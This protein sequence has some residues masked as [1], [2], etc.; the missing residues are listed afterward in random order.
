LSQRALLDSADA[1]L[2]RTKAGTVTDAD[3]DHVLAQTDLLADN[4]DELLVVGLGD[5][6]GSGLIPNA[7]TY[8]ITFIDSAG[9]LI[10]PNDYTNDKR[11][12]YDFTLV[13]AMKL[14]DDD[15]TRDL[16]TAVTDIAAATTKTAYT[17][18]TVT[19]ITPGKYW[20]ML[21]NITVPTTGGT[22]SKIQVWAELLHG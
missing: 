8:W 10:T 2:W 18:Y 3:T 13:K 9:E 7:I 17:R 20:P 6:I 11:G 14:F 21:T 15:A 5:G 19:G 22:V 12:A 4:A 1:I 16:S